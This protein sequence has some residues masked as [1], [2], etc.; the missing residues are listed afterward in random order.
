LPW[1]CRL[2]DISAVNLM[3]LMCAPSGKGSGQL[4]ILMRE[5]AI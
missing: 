1:L 4:L 2:D 3:E 5:D